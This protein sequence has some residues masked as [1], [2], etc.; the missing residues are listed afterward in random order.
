MFYL[1]YSIL[2]EQNFNSLAH[3]TD[4]Y[5]RVQTQMNGTVQYKL[6]KVCTVCIRYNFKC[7]L[8]Q[9]YLAEIAET[10]NVG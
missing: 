8:V 4:V 9:C 5:T 7:T 3:L 6:S 1:V 2:T 10:G